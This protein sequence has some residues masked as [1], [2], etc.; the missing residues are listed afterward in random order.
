MQLHVW[1]P[2]QYK[3]DTPYPRPGTQDAKQRFQKADRNVVSIL[4]NIRV[5]QHSQKPFRCEPLSWSMCTCHKGHAKF[6][7]QGRHLKLANAHV[8][9]STVEV[10]LHP[11]LADLRGGNLLGGISFFYNPN[12]PERHRLHS[13][14]YPL[15]SAHDK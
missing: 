11:Q 15:A 14:T 7:G 8:T 13:R 4:S 2:Q 9:A 10:E 3:P 12:L 1:T 6:S 5:T